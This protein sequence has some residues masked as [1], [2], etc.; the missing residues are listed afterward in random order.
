MKNNMYFRIACIG[1]LII[2]NSLNAQTVF[3]YSDNKKVIP[4][5]DTIAKIQLFTAKY[6]NG[7]IYLHWDVIDQQYNGLYIIFRSFDGKNYEAKGFVNG[8]G[9]TACVPIAY[10]FQDENPN[11]GKTYYKLVHY[12]NNNTCLISEV[13]VIGINQPVED[14]RMALLKHEQHK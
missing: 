14:Q 1:L 8:V 10:Y 3:I 4:S 6:V 11:K 7:K 5:T 9:V 13:L 12:G 2:A